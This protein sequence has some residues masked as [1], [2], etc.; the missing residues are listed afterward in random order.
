[1]DKTT[2]DSPIVQIDFA[3]NEKPPVGG[4]SRFGNELFVN[5]QL[6]EQRLQEGYWEFVDT[7]ENLGGRW[8]RDVYKAH[9]RFQIGVLAAVLLLMLMV[10]ALAFALFGQ[11]GRA[12][13]GVF[14][15]LM[16]LPLV[17]LRTAMLPVL[18]SFERGRQ[19]LA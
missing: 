16:I 8:S 14:V 13:G 17:G 1:M 5:R 10:P 7:L 9:A 4:V 2:P 18:N 12:I 19:H 15:V 6:D 3:R 11:D